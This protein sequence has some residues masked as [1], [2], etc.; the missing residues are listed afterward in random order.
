MVQLGMLSSESMRS[1]SLMLSKLARAGAMD[2]LARKAMRKGIDPKNI[3]AIKQVG[4][5][6]GGNTPGDRKR[7]AQ[8]A[9]N[10]RGFLNKAAA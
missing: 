7:A 10:V 1:M 4:H 9:M 6:A 3:G 5:I 2:F 8:V